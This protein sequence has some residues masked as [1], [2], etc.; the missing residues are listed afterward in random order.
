MTIE[1]GPFVAGEKVG[2]LR[3]TFL[4]SAG[5][6][7]DLT[8]YTVKF[9]YQRHGGTA[10]TGNGVLVTAASGIVG[11]TLAAADLATAGVYKS[12]F[13]VG[14]GTNRYYSD[15]IVY[16]VKTAVAAGTT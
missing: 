9:H 12:H 14:N 13:E 4:D 15:D 3:Y 1:V 16:R 8:G 5:A 7:I 10:T 2:E 11:Y 6:A